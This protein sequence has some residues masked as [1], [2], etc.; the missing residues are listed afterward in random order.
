MRCLF[1]VTNHHYSKEKSGESATQVQVMRNPSNRPRF[2]LLG[3]NL[4]AGTVAPRLSIASDTTRPSA[5]NVTVMARVVQCG[6][7]AAW[8]A[9]IR[10][11]VASSPGFHLNGSLCFRLFPREPFALAPCSLRMRSF[12]SNCAKPTSSV[13]MNS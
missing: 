12:S 1:V 8:R 5:F 2:L 7:P 9:S 13:R 11:E 10:F 3:E 4:G 6:L